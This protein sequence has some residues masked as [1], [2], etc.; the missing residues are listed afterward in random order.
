MSDILRQL[1]ELLARLFGGRTAAA[2]AADEAAAAKAP[3]RTFAE[4]TDPFATGR[5]RQLPTEEL[6]RYTFEA[7][8]AWAGDRGSQ[9]TPNQTPQELVREAL[10]PQTPIYA[11]ARHMVQLYN[12]AAYGAAG[13]SREAALALEPLWRMMRSSRMT[14]ANHAGYLDREKE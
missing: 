11:Q 1:G 4:F 14:T 2:A 8:E 7:F 10:A 9:R 3:R 6:V 12:Q 5:H 13:I